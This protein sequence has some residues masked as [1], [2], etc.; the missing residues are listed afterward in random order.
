MAGDW[1]GDTAWAIRAVRKMSKLATRPRWLMH[2]HLHLDYQRRVGLGGGLLEITGLDRD[3]ADHGNWAILEVAGM[4]WL[5]FPGQARQQRHPRPD[6]NVVSPETGGNMDL[7][8][9]LDPEIAAALASLPILDLSDIPAAR[10]DQYRAT[11]SGLAGGGVAGA[12]VAGARVA[13]A[14][15]WRGPVLGAFGGPGR[16]LGPGWKSCSSGLD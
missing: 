9:R 4:R 11:G 2:G 10:T 1:H 13:G 6:R 16:F 12:G 8:R 14:G 7:D 15:S 5:H 3:G